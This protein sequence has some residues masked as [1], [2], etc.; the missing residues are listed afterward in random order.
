MRDERELREE[1]VGEGRKKVKK[2][3]E[4]RLTNGEGGVYW[5]A[6]PEAGARETAPDGRERKSD[7]KGRRVSRGKERKREE[8]DKRSLLGIPRAES[9]ETRRKRKETKPCRGNPGGEGKREEK[10]RDARRA[11]EGGEPER[12]ESRRGA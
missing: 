8:T 4:K 10:D 11:E 5:A 7:R 12:R 6:P 2:K 3:G 9:A 1:G